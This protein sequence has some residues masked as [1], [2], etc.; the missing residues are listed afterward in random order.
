MLNNRS[1]PPASELRYQARLKEHN[2]EHQ[3]LIASH[4]KEM[5]ELRDK[6]SL[7]LDRFESLFDH[8]E[9]QTKERILEIE[10]KISR[11][12]GRAKAHEIL[13]D[14]NKN[15]L[16]DLQQEHRD[17]YRI[18][19][20]KI[21]VEKIEKNCAAKFVEMT[22]QHLNAYQSLEQQVASIISDAQVDFID[23]KNDTE[24]TFEKLNEDIDK[25]FSQATMDKEGV[26]KEIRVY[27]KHMFIMERKIENLY[28]LI[29]RMKKGEVCHKQES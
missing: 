23:H 28:T 22:T 17:L 19:S 16:F 4:H 14:H 15:T 5:Q 13:I 26:L 27:K 1:L 24:L 25:K 3:S 12:S 20:Y 21:D 2:I 18:F 8:L 10:A 7:T 29:E 11:L 6:L 9:M